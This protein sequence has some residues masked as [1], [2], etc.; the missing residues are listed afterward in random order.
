VCVCV[1]V[2]VSLQLDVDDNSEI[3]STRIEGRA[4]LSI[5]NSLQYFGGVPDDYTIVT[6][7]IGSSVRFIGC[8]S[9]VIINSRCVCRR[10]LPLVMSLVL[11]T[12]YGFSNLHCRL[13]LPP[14]W[15]NGNSTCFVALP[16][17][18]ISTMSEHCS[19]SRICDIPA[20]LP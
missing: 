3:I 18:Q 13:L 8:I 2:C 16:V 17:I 5:R 4:R 12:H 20:T 11:L 7:N 9:D 19:S 6:N 10:H 15:K 14:L 1:C